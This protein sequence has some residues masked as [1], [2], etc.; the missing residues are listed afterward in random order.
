[1]YLKNDDIDSVSEAMLEQY[2]V[3]VGMADKVSERRG[4]VNTFF[5]SVHTILLGAVGL[6]G[7]DVAKY[8][9]IIV[10]LGLV[11]SYV[12]FYLIQSYKLLNSGKFSVICDS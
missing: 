5:I 10:L 9:W 6:N 11:L 2:K 12:W 4:G 1:M 8:W 7:F 3:Y